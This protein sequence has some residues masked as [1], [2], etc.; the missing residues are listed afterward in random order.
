MEAKEDDGF[1]VMKLSD[2]EDLFECLNRAIEEFSIE[3][4]CVLVGVGML[5]DVKIGYLR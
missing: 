5:S 4:G 3:S 2:G 1:V